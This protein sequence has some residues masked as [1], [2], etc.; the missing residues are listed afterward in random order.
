MEETVYDEGFVDIAKGVNY[1]CCLE[2][3]ER[4]KG[5]YCIKGNLGG[6]SWVRQSERS[7]D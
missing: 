2:G 1:Y 3:E 7:N 6:I 4:N 5:G